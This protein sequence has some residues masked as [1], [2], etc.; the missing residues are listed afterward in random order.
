[1]NQLLEGVITELRLTW[2]GNGRCL[3]RSSLDSDQLL[4]RDRRMLTNLHH[5]GADDLAP[6]QSFA[7]LEATEPS[8]SV[9]PVAGL[10][11][12]LAS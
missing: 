9:F 5:S 1:M 2:S 7:P 6:S 3:A 8:F 11:A 4:N 10:G 12:A